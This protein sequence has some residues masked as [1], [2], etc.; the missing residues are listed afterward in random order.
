M[1]DG[2][3]ATFAHDA[4]YTRVIGQRAD[5]AFAFWDYGPELSRRFRA[6]KVWM[7][8]KTGRDAGACRVD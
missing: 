4:D 3:R 5:E 7:L 6:L 2:A 1:P 8:I